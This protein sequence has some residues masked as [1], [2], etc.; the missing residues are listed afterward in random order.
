[1]KAIFAPHFEK[2]TFEI[3]F[4]HEL[5]LFPKDR[6]TLRSS[7]P[8]SLISRTVDVE[9]A[10]EVSS[11]INVG[12]IC[13]EMSQPRATFRQFFLELFVLDGFEMLVN[14]DRYSLA[15]KVGRC[16]DPEPVCRSVA[17]C[18]QRH[19]YL[20][21]TRIRFQ[22]CEAKQA[23][24]ETSR[25]CTFHS[26]PNEYPKADIPSTSD[27]YSFL[28]WANIRAITVGKDWIWIWDKELEVFSTTVKRLRDWEGKH[29]VKEMM[30]SSEAQTGDFRPHYIKK[31]L[32][33]IGVRYP[34]RRGT[35][36]EEWSQALESS[37]GLKTRLIPRDNPQT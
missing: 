36:P 35:T 24:T 12:K 17:E 1:M 15:I 10:A 32:N 6:R 29:L 4:S 26:H 9:D 18:V 11:K 22:R 37:I 34:K 33:A 27:I 5:P 2:H 14:A 3:H 19:F 13:L 23:F 30:R 28:K 16:F 8:K 20:T 31:A 25:A 21:K 7:E